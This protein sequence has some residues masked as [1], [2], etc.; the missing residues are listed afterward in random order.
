MYIV[1]RK[2]MKTETLIN[3]VVDKSSTYTTTATRY[4]VLGFINNPEELE[5]LVQDRLD[6]IVNTG[7]YSTYSG[8][9]IESIKKTRSKANPDQEIY[10]V[11]VLLHRRESNSS[12]QNNSD[13]RRIS[14][15]ETIKY[16]LLGPIDTNRYLRRYNTELSY[17]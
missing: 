14:W 5:L 9:E 6:Y 1:V 12:G 7:R 8:A 3:G 11:K 16:Y 2:M 17:T 4:N 13:N 15:R 10:L